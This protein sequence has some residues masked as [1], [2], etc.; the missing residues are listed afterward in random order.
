MGFWS[1]FPAKMVSWFSGVHNNFFL[2]ISLVESE[3]ADK[4][5][6]LCRAELS[7]AAW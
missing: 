1:D 7:C 2:E 5:V 3:T 6:K 4:R